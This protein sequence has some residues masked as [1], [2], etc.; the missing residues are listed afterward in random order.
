MELSIL[1]IVP[2]ARRAAGQVRGRRTEEALGVSATR[3][4]GGGYASAFT[5]ML[6]VSSPPIIASPRQFFP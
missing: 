2:E 3:G 4:G 6:S 5:Q 1:V